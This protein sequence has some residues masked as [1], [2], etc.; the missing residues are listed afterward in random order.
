MGHV[1]SPD[2]M[3]DEFVRYVSPHYFDAMRIKLLAGR[4][5]DRRDLLSAPPVVLV[6]EAFARKFFHNSSPLGQKLLVG[7]GM[8]PPFAGQP[9]EIVGVVG[10]THEQGL[11]VPP[12]PVI[13]ENLAQVP[14][15]LMNL[16]VKLIPLHWVIR[17]NGNPL[18]FVPQIRR[19]TLIASGGIP[20][21][22]PRTLEDYVGNSI[23]QQRFLMTLLSIFAALAVFLG[24]IGIYGVMSY[25]VARRT[26]ELGIRT[27]LGAKRL[28]LLQL[29]VKQGMTMA[30]LGL[31]VGLFASIGLTRFLRSMLFDVTPTDPRVLAS[32]AALL[33]L[34]A[35]AA[36]LIPA[37]RAASV[38]PVIALREE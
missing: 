32:V 18:A 27:A 1:V 30:A 23:A 34:V 36:C 6:N 33:A 2:K 17:T 24:S 29:V 19:E 15:H 8:G 14:N 7:A 31:L 10:D 38:D 26:R 35:L 5:F 16:F 28:D 25:G 20:L 3:P 13:F 4:D 37:R 11:A 12:D 22:E 21:A 9:R